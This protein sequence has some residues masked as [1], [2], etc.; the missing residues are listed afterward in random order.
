MKWNSINVNCT[1]DDFSEKDVQLEFVKLDSNGKMLYY[2]V[3][4]PLELLKSGFVASC[5]TKILIHGWQCK[6][7]SDIFEVLPH[8]YLKSG[9]TNVILVNW[10]KGSSTFY[11]PLAAQCRTRI[12]GQY[13]S[14][15]LKN[16]LH[17]HHLGSTSVFCVGHSLGAHICGFVGKYLKPEFELGMKLLFD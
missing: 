13:V 5:N 16:L 1:N 6:R 12:V 14:K 15:F 7:T 3:K 8:A 11:Y 10:I 17:E 2:P 4:T 9:K